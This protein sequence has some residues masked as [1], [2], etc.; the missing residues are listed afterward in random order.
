M[1]QTR[2]KKMKNIS[3]IFSVFFVFAASA[4]LQEMDIIVNSNVAEDYSQRI[5]RIDKSK[6]LNAV[7]LPFEDD[8]SKDHF[9][10][11]EAGNEVLWNGLTANRNLS[12]GDNPP[13]I[14]VVTLDGLNATGYPHDGF[15]GG[16]I[17]NAD[18]LTSVGINLLDE[19]NVFLSFFFQ[20]GGLGDDPNNGDS[21][22]LEFFN[23]DNNTWDWNWGMNGNIGFT[24]FEQIILPI[25]QATYLHDNFQ[26]RFRNYATADGSF[27]HWN[28]DYLRLDAN[29][30]I[31]DTALVDI[32]FAEPIYSLL[33]ED[34]VSIPWTHYMNN[35]PSSLTTDQKALGVRNLRSSLAFI[36]ET[37]MT[38]EYNGSEQISFTDAASPS[39]PAY[40]DLAINQEIG[41]SPNNYFFDPNVNTISAEFDVTAFLTSSPNSNSENDTYS[42]SQKFLNY[43]D[44]SDNSAERSFGLSIKDGNA[45]IAVKVKALQSDSLEAV[46]M[47]FYQAGINLTNGLILVTVWD[48]DGQNGTPGTILYQSEDV[49]SPEFPNQIGGYKVYFLAEKILVDQS[50]YIGFKQVSE[51]FISV[52]LDK[53]TIS[54]EEK[55]YY[56]LNNDSFL[57][58]GLSGTALMRPQ[59][60]SDIE[61]VGVSENLLP[62]DFIAYPNPTSDFVNIK[63]N[64]SRVFQSAQFY[65]QLG[66]FVG[67]KTI[68]SNRINVGSL[69]EGIYH[70]ILIDR[71]KQ[72]SIS[73]K[74]VIIK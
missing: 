53:N 17:S 68:E 72:K 55:I 13:S 10:G 45:N 9:E 49:L 8:F 52:G 15:I 35:G 30:N 57:P 51:D 14:G 12:W 24:D 3:L 2:P 25:D 4:Q 60:L 39:I 63:H 58:S 6:S 1:N 65:D 21:L 23:I 38:V 5:K 29:R 59:Y 34:Y 28:I 73:Q 37:G 20:A 62:V 16:N 36:N 56:N 66:R 61:Y 41:A 44:Y 70:V 11:N 26:F 50:Y 64:S 48:D 47:S 71:D 43:Y 27:D 19:Q 18:T 32:C 22:I 42:F 40:T 74:I 7:G 54:S 31:N 33:N 69:E 67:N 46:Q